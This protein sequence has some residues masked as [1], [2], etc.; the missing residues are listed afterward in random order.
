MIC[1][2]IE[3]LQNALN[4]KI[5]T[6]LKD[7]K[8]YIEYLY[9]ENILKC[10][11]CITYS[12]ACRNIVNTTKTSGHTSLEKYTSHTFFEMVRKG[13]ERV[14]VWGAGWKLNKDCNILT[15]SSSGY[16][17][18]SFSS[19]E[20]A[21]PGTLRARLSAESGSHCFKL[22]PLTPNSDLQLTQT[23]CSTGFYNFLT[24]TCFSE[25]CICTQFNLSSVNIFDRMH[26]LFT[27]V[28]FLF[29]SSAGSEVNMLHM[30]TPYNEISLKF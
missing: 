17:S 8:R 13:Y 9:L 7:R 19:Y 26:L 2:L 6:L 15:P 18:T 12:Y 16:S 27:L 30:K 4:G 10:T 22:Q 14:I 29:D 20:A 28:H 1:Y 5:S 23:S 21:Q 11:I 3:Q 25:L 24:F